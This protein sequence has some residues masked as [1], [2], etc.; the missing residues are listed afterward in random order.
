MTTRIADASRVGH[1]R[2]TGPTISDG[3]EELT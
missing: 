1:R 2:V 3:N